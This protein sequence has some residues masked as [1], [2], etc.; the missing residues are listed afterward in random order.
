M[1]ARGEWNATAAYPTSLLPFT[2]KLSIAKPVVPCGP[3]L[4]P[5][6]STSATPTKR[7][8]AQQQDVAAADDI[9][10]DQGLQSTPMSCASSLP[11]PHD[12]AASC[13]DPRAREVHEALR[14]DQHW[15]E[16]EEEDQVVHVIAP[17]LDVHAQAQIILKGQAP[18]AKTEQVS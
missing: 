9:D 15:A 18:L 6:V 7:A 12:C 3:Q 16:D 5:S 14:R 10:M 4:P 8:S 2:G 17:H 1:G 11:A 13:C